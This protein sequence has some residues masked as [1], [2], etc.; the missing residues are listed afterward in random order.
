MVAEFT[1]RRRN[2]RKRVLQKAQISFGFSGSTIDCL[3]SNE[4]AFGVLIE[5][6]A[7]MTLPNDIMLR[8]NNGDMRPAVVRWTLGTKIGVEFQKN[9][10]ICEQKVVSQRAAIDLENIKIRISM[11]KDEPFCHKPEI[12]AMVR[13]VEDCFF[14]LYARLIE[15]E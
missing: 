14:V 5:T 3:V 11:L 9:S 7:P 13:N 6:A 10:N 2:T 4:A 8:V 12:L 1:E 15:I